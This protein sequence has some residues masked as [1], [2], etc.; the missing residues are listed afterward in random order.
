MTERAKKAAMNCK[1]AW[2]R[3]A[4]L[5]LAW[6][7]TERVALEMRAQYYEGLAAGRVP[8]EEDELVIVRDI[9]RK[10]RAHRN[11]TAAVELANQCEAELGRALEDELAP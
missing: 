4:E 3:A 2:R 8:T 10:H 11:W 9:Q 5:G 6:A 1:D 7:E